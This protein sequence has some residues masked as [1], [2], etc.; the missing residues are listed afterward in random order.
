MNRRNELVITGIGVVLPGA[1]SVGEFWT[2]LVRGRSQVG[3][4]RPGIA[5]HT[6]VKLAAQL[7][8]L[9]GDRMLPRLPDAHRKKYSREM[10]ATMIALEAALEDAAVDD[11]VDRSRVGFID[12][13]SRG[14]AEYWHASRQMCRGEDPFASPLGDPMMAGL[15]GSPAC[16]AAMYSGLHGMV[17]TVASACVGGNHAL[18]IAANELR[19]GAADLM[20]VGGHEFP[21]IPDVVQMYSYPGRAVL[22][23]GTEPAT[24]MRPYHRDRDGF[25]LGEGAIVLAVERA[26]SAARRGA[27]AYASVLGAHHIN[28]AAHPTRMDISGRATATMIDALLTRTGRAPAEAGYVCGH[29]TATHYNDIAES[30]AL[31]VVWE[32]RGLPRP[33]LGSVKPVYGHLFGAAS[34][35]NIAATALMLHHQTLVPTLNLDHPDPECDHDHVA[36]GARPAHLELAVSLSFAIGSQS[37][38]V[39]LGRA[40]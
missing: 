28:E 26:E 7:P 33:P 32:K 10:Q 39:A 38:C 15:P 22:S 6:P 35:L 37:S 8:V 20:F 18:S 40:A 25:V 36:E 27:R 30:R 12:S 17:A 13:S 21:L 19:A 29:G 5:D 9:D 4:I 14:P 34:T 3:P 31:G 23:R 11:Q 24:A 2:N 1:L 16:F